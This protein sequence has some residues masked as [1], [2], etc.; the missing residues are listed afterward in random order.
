MGYKNMGIENNEKDE[1]FLSESEVN[2]LAKKAKEGYNDPAWTKLYTNFERY[3]HY[4]ARKILAKLNLT[5]SKK[6]DIED[7]LSQVG[8]EGFISAIKKFDPKT[9]KL[10]THATP[11]IDG[12]MYHE[13]DTQLNTLGFSNR[14][15]AKKNSDGR[16]TTVSRAD[17]DVCTMLSNAFVKSDNGISVPDAPDKGKYSADRGVLQL[18]E[19]LRLTTDEKH[20]VSKKELGECLRLYR[21]AKLKNGT[22]PIA[23]NTLTAIMENMLQEINPMEYSEENE[24]EYRVKYD[25][26]K[27]NLLKQK[28][29]FD[30]K[31]E[32]KSD[33]AGKTKGD[34]KGKAPTISG[35]SY[36]HLFSDAQLDSLIQLICFSEMISVD[37]KQELIRRL[38]TTVSL[39]YE[40][41]F[42]R[43]G[44]LLFNPRAVYGRFGSRNLN[45]KMRFA[46]N[47]KIIQQAI[48]SLWQIRFRF[49]RYTDDHKMIPK[50]DYVHMLSPYHLVVYHDNIYCI[51]K[52]KGDK[53]IW[54]YRIDLM[55]DIEIVRNKN[56]KPVPIE[57][58]KFDGLPISNSKWDPEKYMSEHLNM[59]YDEPRD[60]LTK[61]KNDD[62]TIIH[63]WFGNH[64]E[65]VDEMAGKD[66]A[67][68]DVV[69]DVVKV[70]T[71]PSMIVHWAMQYGTSV[72]ILDEEIR[73]KINKK[74]LEIRRIYERS[75]V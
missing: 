71:S 70:K 28:L 41:P 75:R 43:D 40:S 60:I 19:I 6:A 47:L 74:I 1:G 2:D 65:K 7:D 4:R 34:K 24:K 30:K 27:E 45:E 12:N 59:A 16:N 44:K 46:E 25:G 21:V 67:G 5:D 72:E 56:G 14:S 9:S 62:Y 20:T 48:N 66:D 13:L 49:N 31:S 68:K 64:Y 58:T 38:M 10:L 69:Y 54:H 15:K 36:V 57:L 73:E 32:G 51:G 8:W 33:K 35:F 17:I 53:R 3:I 22:P 52:K 23:D 39:Y 42:W 29:E 26:Y 55:S 61:I 11:Y 50:D 37:E 18:L 63:D